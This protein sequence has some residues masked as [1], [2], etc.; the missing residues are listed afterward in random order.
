MRG[1]FGSCGPEVEWLGDP[2]LTGAFF[3]WAVAFVDQLIDVGL[4]VEAFSWEQSEELA[5]NP[6]VV[7]DVF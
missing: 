1:A 6:P 3:D 2:A 4:C 5:V 7:H